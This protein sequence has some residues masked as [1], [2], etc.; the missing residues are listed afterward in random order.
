MKTNNNFIPLSY[1]NPF[2]KVYA[3]V[4]VRD[5][6]ADKIFQNKNL[7]VKFLKDFIRN[8]DDYVIVYISISN[9]DVP[10]FMECMKDLERLMLLTGHTESV[11]IINDL[12]KDLEP[13]KKGKLQCL[14]EK[15]KKKAN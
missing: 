3:Y 15:R 4:D 7:K 14:I 8:D 1:I 10:L 6:K 13:K 5:Y 2:K 9:K 12:I 11:N